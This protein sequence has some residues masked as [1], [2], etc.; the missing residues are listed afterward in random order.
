MS[1]LRWSC[2]HCQQAR[3]SGRGGHLDEPVCQPTGIQG[4]FERF[5]PGGEADPSGSLSPL[6]TKTS[7]QGSC[8]GVEQEESC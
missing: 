7:V 2:R 5:R 8:L 4:K 6:Q 1:S 3:R